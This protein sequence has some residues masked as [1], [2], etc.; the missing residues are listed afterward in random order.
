MKQRDMNTLKQYAYIRDYIQEHGY[1]P[2][3]LEIQ[4]YMGHSSRSSTHHHMK[5][6]FKAGL[7][8][9]DIEGDLLPRAYRLARNPLGAR[10]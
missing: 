2:S 10:I 7:L 3:L 5:K 9:T 6:L 1:A 4:E 8:E